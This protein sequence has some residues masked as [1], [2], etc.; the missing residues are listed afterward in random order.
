MESQNWR[1]HYEGKSMLKVSISMK[2]HKDFRM[3]TPS[4]DRTTMDV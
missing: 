1:I 4:V 2:L 3:G